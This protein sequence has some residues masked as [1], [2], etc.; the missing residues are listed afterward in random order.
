MGEKL[1]KKE[2]VTLKR[3]VNQTRIGLAGTAAELMDGSARGTAIAAAIRAEL[4]EWNELYDKL[5]RME[6]EAKTWAKN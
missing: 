6:E 1:T 2:L 3:L 4:Q 5:A